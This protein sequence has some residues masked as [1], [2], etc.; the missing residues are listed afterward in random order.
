MGANTFF[1]TADG[2]TPKKA[3][4][5]ACKDAAYDYGHS[6]YTGTLA[7]KESFIMISDKIF[8]SL[9]EAESLADKLIDDGDER[10]DDKWGPAGC[11]KFK[12]KTGEVKFLFFGWA[13]S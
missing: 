13:S 9:E 5:A 3:F 1:Q 12:T 10:I 11:L 2:K 6:G 4:I 7:E 8:D